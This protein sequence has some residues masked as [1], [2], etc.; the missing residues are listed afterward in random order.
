L[1]VS[2]TRNYSKSVAQVLSYYSELARPGYDERIRISVTKLYI[3]YW[4]RRCVR[5]ASLLPVL[6]LAPQLAIV[7]CPGEKAVAPA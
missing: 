3:V 1:Q 2:S 4:T 6:P 5:I 7:L